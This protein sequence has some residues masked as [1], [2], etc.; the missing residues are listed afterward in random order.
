MLT[1]DEVRKIYHEAERLYSNEEVQSALDNMASDIERDFADKLPVVLPVMA[2]AVI[3]TGH[4]MTRLS[5]PLEI[6]YIHATRYAN[7]T[8]GGEISWLAKPTVDL[9]GRAVII[10]DDII[11]EGITLDKIVEYCKNEGAS[12]V[13]CAVL[14]DKKHDRKKGALQADYVGLEI[15]DRYIFGYG[16]D[17]KGYLRNADGIYAVKGL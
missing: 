8:K 10:L 5:F 6:N 13:A 3:V 2:G 7:D 16:M 11:D 9:D 17:Y 12:E 4:L 15:E 14:I 1:P